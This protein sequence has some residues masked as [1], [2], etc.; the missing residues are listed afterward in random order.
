MGLDFLKLFDM[1]TPILGGKPPFKREIKRNRAYMHN[2][3]STQWDKFFTDFQEGPVCSS[4]P[5]W[6]ERRRCRGAGPSSGWRC[7]EG[8]PC[9]ETTLRPIL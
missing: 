8:F 3:M 9:G 6:L 7:K 2:K 4:T 1:A 5:A